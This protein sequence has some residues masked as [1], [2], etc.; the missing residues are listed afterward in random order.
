MAYRQIWLAQV[1]R[2]AGLNVVEV[3]GWQTRG[4]GEM[5]NLLG[6][7]CHHTAGSRNGDAPSL[8]VV[9]DGR[10][11]VSGPLAQLV[12]ARSGTYHVVAA[13]KCWHAGKGAWRGIVAGSTHFIGIEAENTGLDNDQPWP[14]VQMDAYSTGVAAILKHIGAQPEFCIGHKE[15]APRRKID[16][17]FDMD[18]FRA[19]VATKMGAIAASA[20]SSGRPVL[21]RGDTGE[22]VRDLQKAIGVPAD[23]IF[24]PATETAVR[25][26]QQRAGLTVDGV[27]G[28]KTWAAI[29]GSK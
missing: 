7:M 2:D 1:L 23:G 3:P 10:P 29:D 11:D 25:A 22:G 24:G 15:F 14:A 17:T 5:G 6:V 19:V 8:A 21:G 18:A 26:L 27:V 12:L 9:R 20:K 16:P 4:H 13:G 28:P